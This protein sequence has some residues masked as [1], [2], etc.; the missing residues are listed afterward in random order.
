MDRNEAHA[1]FSSFVSH[2]FVFMNGFALVAYEK[3]YYL[4][5]WRF[6]S[7]SRSLPPSFPPFLSLSATGCRAT[8]SLGDTCRESVALFQLEWK[9]AANRY[10]SQFSPSTEPPS[11]VPRKNEFE[12]RS[13][14]ES[15][16]TENRVP[17]IGRY[18]AELLI[19][20]VSYLFLY[21]IAMVKRKML[22]D[23]RLVRTNTIWAR[24]GKFNSVSSSR[25][26]RCSWE[27][28]DI[29]EMKNIY[30]LDVNDIF[31]Y[32]NIKYF[33]SN[34]IDIFWKSWPLMKDFIPSE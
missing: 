17:I 32:G 24:L 7:F 10:F 22:F 21:E 23:A 19:T 3:S 8:S 27:N 31:T 25:I 9:T 30:L 16:R 6:R 33:S 29:C 26:R 15:R 5:D 18:S 11:T 2:G 1:C 20:G 13:R 4:R 12:I 28:K 34:K 14:R